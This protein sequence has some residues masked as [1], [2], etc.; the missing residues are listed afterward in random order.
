[1]TVAL[2]AF[3]YLGYYRWSDPIE[4][5]WVSYIGCAVLTVW[6]VWQQ[7]GRRTWVGLFGI[8]YI[9]FEGAQQ[10]TC[11][12][13]EF[14]TVPDGQDICVRLV[15]EEVYRAAMSIILA[16]IFTGAIKWQNRQSEK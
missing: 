8:F 15:G 4:R 14:G 6:L 9:T 3:A 13:F 16:V 5:A 1:V 11:G 10:A 12:Y 7:T 2:A